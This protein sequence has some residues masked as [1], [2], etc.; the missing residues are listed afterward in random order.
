MEREIEMTPINLKISENLKELLVRELIEPNYK[1]EVVRLLYGKTCWRQTGQVFETMSK[2]LV[3]IGGII[4]FAA[5][6]YNIHTLSFVAGAIS[7]I[8]LATLQFSAFAF[9]E[10]K[11]QGVE[12]NNILKKLKL[13]EVPLNERSSTDDVGASFRSTSPQKTPSIDSTESLITENAALKEEIIAL[14]NILKQKSEDEKNDEKN[15]VV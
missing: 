6:S 7:T 14:S 12:L 11:K 5:G 9:R 13:D 1:D 15:N 3:A 10:N 2:A 8:S 4:S